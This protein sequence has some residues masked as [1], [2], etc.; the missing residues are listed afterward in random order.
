MREWYVSPQLVFIRAGEQAGGEGSEVTTSNPG[1]K[2]AGSRKNKAT[3]T[4]EKT[5]LAAEEKRAAL[6]VNKKAAT[7]VELE[8]K[9]LTLAIE[10]KKALVRHKRSHR[11]WT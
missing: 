10:E 6:E 4:A 2:E 9:M 3:T 7:E 5:F 11:K 1:G 8:R